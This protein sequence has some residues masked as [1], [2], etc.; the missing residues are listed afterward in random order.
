MKMLQIKL[1][2]AWFVLHIWW[3]D[4]KFPCSPPPPFSLLYFSKQ[5]STKTIFLK[6][7]DK[8]VSWNILEGISLYDK[9][10]SL[11]II[12]QW[13]LYLANIQGNVTGVYING[14]YLYHKSLGRVMHTSVILLILKSY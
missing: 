3:V 12:I 10:N 6:T 13:N 1:L 7:N 14:G 2:V 8:N 5:A 11:T 4:L 9:Q